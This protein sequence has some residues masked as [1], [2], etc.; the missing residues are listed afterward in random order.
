VKRLINGVRYIGSSG[1]KTWKQEPGTFEN[2]GYDEGLGVGTSAD[3]QQL[4]DALQHADA[5]VTKT[6]AHTYHFQ[7]TKA[8]DTQYATGQRTFTG[9]VT[10]DAGNRIAKVTYE[11][12]D[13]GQMKP[14]A[15]DGVAYEST[16]VASTELSDYGLPVVVEK[17]TKVVVAR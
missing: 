16:Y 2:L 8:Y 9:D 1:S 6:G 11:S 5:T 4:L 13:K 7:S 12:T 10:L 14:G 17:P 15:K 3:P